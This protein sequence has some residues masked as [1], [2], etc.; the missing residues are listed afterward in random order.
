MAK[1]DK[2]DIVIGID[3][4]VDRSGFA[5]L[6]S[7]TRK[8]DLRALSFPDLLDALKTVQRKCEVAGRSLT[9][10]VEAGWLNESNWHLSHR[11]SRAEAAAK[12]NAVG[13][14]HETGRK[15]CEMCDHWDIPVVRKKPLPLKS[16]GVHFW[17]GKDGKI[18]S[19]ELKA[20]TGYEKRT[21]QEMRD[22]A[23]LAWTHADLPIVV[24]PK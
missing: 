15:I 20:L 3:P 16:R 11:E 22:A 14:N 23:L 24:R 17:N 6:D 18:T 10:V 21:N 12:G 4:D 5:L 8:F 13:R 9:V 7:R 2:I 19:E 1:T